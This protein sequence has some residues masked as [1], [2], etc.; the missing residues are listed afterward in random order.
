MMV[1]G[2]T[3]HLKMKW[4]AD[5]L[6]RDHLKPD[7][8]ASAARPTADELVEWGKVFAPSPPGDRFKALPTFVEQGR[9]LAED[10]AAIAA[11]DQLGRMT[12]VA[13]VETVL[14]YHFSL[15]LVRLVNALYEELS[16]IEPSLQFS[17][18]SP[19]RG[20][21]AQIRFRDRRQRFAPEWA[22]DYEV[23]TRMLNE[24]YLLLPV[25]NAI[26]VAIRAACGAQR[27]G[28]QDLQWADVRDKKLDQQTSILA[29]DLLRF[30][31][32]MAYEDCAEKPRASSLRE[33][34]ITALFDALRFH[35]TQPEQVRFPREHHQLVFEQTALQGPGSFRQ[36]RPRK[37]FAI[38]QDLLQVLV[39]VLFRQDRG[40]RRVPLR[41]LEQR[42]LDDLL[43]PADGH[44]RD[45]L[46]ESLRSLGLLD[47]LSDVGEA[48]FLRCPSSV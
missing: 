13:A 30:W 24:A 47:R 40:E 25:L 12:R 34:P 32:A 31:T 45:A 26:E 28:M 6:V 4:G 11:A 23:T 17:H 33:Q 3:R 39:F 18:A 35:Y 29:A 14:G 21:V 22:D 20:R 16:R 19:W 10:L 42:L 7:D 41:R 15:Y 46:V 1:A 43:V 44:A 9:R 48:Q 37:H 2:V 36:V 38:G 5:V 8:L 27:V